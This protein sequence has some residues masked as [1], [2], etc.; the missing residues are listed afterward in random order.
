MP[1]SYTHLHKV[2]LRKKFITK[3][4]IFHKED[5]SS[6]LSFAN[7]ENV[8]CNYIN[9]SKSIAEKLKVLNYSEIIKYFD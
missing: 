4:S 8:I 3:S 2:G 9:E 1:V 5:Q 6:S 7:D